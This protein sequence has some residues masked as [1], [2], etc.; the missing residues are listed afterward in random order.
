MTKLT[1]RD[2]ERLKANS[3]D[4]NGFGPLRRRGMNARLSDYELRQQI[5]ERTAQGKPVRLLLEEYEYR[6]NKTE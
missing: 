5:E 6:M 4:P 3:V 1:R 2:Y